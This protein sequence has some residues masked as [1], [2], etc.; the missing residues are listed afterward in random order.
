M[1]KTVAKVTDI[2]SLLIHAKSHGWEAEI[3]KGGHYKVT[4]P[5]GQVVF[6]AATPGDRRAVL[7][8]LSDMIRL[9]LPKPVGS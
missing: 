9:G 5:N 1:A 8:S 3:R 4:G 7:N 6:T 2:K